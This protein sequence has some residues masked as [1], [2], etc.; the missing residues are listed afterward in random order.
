M[1]KTWFRAYCYANENKLFRVYKPE[2]YK[3]MIRGCGFEPEPMEVTRKRIRTR[4]FHICL[5]KKHEGEISISKQ[6]LWMEHLV[7]LCYLFRYRLSIGQI[8][9][10]TEKVEK[11]RKHLMNV[12][13]DIEIE[14]KINL[15]LL[16]ALRQNLDRAQIRE[17]QEKVL[18]LR[19]SGKKIH[20]MKGEDIL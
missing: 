10:N 7:F 20:K 8:R 5:D 16:R 18:Q 6:D 1:D 19:C 11:Y 2:R 14:K 3:K 13:V 9:K 4:F 15:V 17:I 12:N